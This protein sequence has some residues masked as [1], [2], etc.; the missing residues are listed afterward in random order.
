MTDETF[1]LPAKIKELHSSGLIVEM[2]FNV[3]FN[4]DASGYLLIAQVIIRC[5]DLHLHSL[6]CV[7][8]LRIRICHLIN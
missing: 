7:L 6:F 8:N 3:V 2:T 4:V 5:H 1:F